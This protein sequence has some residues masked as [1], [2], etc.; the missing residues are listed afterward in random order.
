MTSL[1]DVPSSSGNW[2]T[3]LYTQF[4]GGNSSLEQMDLDPSG[5]RGVGWVCSLGFGY[6][7]CKDHL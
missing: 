5:S 3:P 1:Q 4:G 2:S 7:F 6:D